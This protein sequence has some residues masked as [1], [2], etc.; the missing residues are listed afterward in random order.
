MSK[1]MN[2]LSLR[3]II[4]EAKPP[5]FSKVVYAPA[6]AIGYNN[7]DIQATSIMPE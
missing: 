5:H 3:A 6:F 1:Y 2:W 4:L 7:E